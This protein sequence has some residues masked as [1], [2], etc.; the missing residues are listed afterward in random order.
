MKGAGRYI[1]G[2]IGVLIVVLIATTAIIPETFSG[3]ADLE[4]DVNVPAW[5][6]GVLITVAGAGFLYLIWKVFSF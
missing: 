2:M 5:V 4:T 1:D 6:S 3:L